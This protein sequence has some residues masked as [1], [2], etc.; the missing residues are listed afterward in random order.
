MLALLVVLALATNE[1]EPCNPKDKDCAAAIEK[2]E[3]EDLDPAI[4]FLIKKEDRRRKK[5]S[6]MPVCPV[7]PGTYWNME[8]A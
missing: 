2:A 5:V 4:L 6:K 7:P 8:C 3:A 1:P